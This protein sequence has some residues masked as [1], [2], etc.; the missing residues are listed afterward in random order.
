[1]VSDITNHGK[2][3]STNSLSQILHFWTPLL[4]N[5]EYF[6]VHNVKIADFSQNSEYFYRLP[7]LSHDRW[8]ACF[9]CEK[10]NWF[11]AIPFTILSWVCALMSYFC[12]KIYLLVLIMIS[13]NLQCIY[14]IF[15]IFIYGWLTLLETQKMCSE[16]QVS[17]QKMFRI[18]HK[19]LTGGVS[20]LD[21]RFKKAQCL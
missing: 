8:Q 3:H 19:K 21:Q 4:K 17:V 12:P 1:M 18:M 6:G 10:I 9:R 2:N 14:P 20:A 15:Y 13:F 16:F 5:S 7:K 11:W